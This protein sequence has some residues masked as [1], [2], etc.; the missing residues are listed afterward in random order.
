MDECNFTCEPL[1]FSQLLDNIEEGILVAIREARRGK[2]YLF[3]VLCVYSSIVREECTF[4]FD[5]MCL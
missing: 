5:P 1:Y 4:T 3:V 2:C